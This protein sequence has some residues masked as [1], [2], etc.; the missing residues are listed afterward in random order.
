MNGQ[1][2]DQA[3]SRAEARQSANAR[4][5]APAPCSNEWDPIGVGPDGPKDEYDCLLWPVMRKLEDGA[6]EE[7]LV[8]FLVS[9]LEGHF[10]LTGDASNVEAFAS[11]A[12]NWFETS[13]KGPRD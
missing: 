6:P 11:R 5:R 4:A 12:R 2:S 13:W 9:E 7:Q 10:G 3:P 1:Q 8:T